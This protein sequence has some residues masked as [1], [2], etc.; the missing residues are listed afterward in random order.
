MHWGAIGACWGA[1]KIAFL[2]E[3]VLICP[4]SMPLQLESRGMQKKRSKY[5]NSGKWHIGSWA[6]GQILTWGKFEDLD[7]LNTRLGISNSTWFSGIMV[8]KY[9][10]Y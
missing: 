6:T 7:T 1:I 10:K 5:G 8:Y 4:R 9:L 2:R 3:C